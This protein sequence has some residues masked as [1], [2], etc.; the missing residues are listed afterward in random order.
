LKEEVIN[1]ID[2][3]NIEGFKTDGVL[4]EKFGSDIRSKINEAI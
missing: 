1:Y 3:D 2:E 4:I